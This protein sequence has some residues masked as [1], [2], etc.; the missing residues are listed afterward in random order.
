[1]KPGELE[2]LCSREF[3]F[4]EVNDQPYKLGLG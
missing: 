1:M 2:A 4:K 3:H